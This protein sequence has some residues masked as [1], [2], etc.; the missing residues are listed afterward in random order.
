VK[1]NWPTI[2]E[3]TRHR[4]VIVT[5][6]N[7]PEAVI[8]SVARY[9]EL[10]AAAGAHD[11]LHHLRQDFYDELAVLR[12]ESAADQL[13]EIFAAAPEEIARAANTAA[14]RDGE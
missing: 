9:A 1:A 11:P 6:S 8:I 7:K 14:S 10:K 3:E 2:V 13:R 4:E 5:N 12:T